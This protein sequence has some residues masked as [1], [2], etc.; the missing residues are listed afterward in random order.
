MA[1]VRERTSKRTNVTR[2]AV[3]YRKGKRQ[4]STTF[5]TQAG[6]DRFK[7]LV[8]L[9]GPEKAEATLDEGRQAGIT[10][11]DLF[12]KWIEWKA[13]TDVT[14]R[15]LRDYRRDYDNWIRARFGNREADGIDEL[16][17]QRWVDWM[18]GRGADPKSIGDRHMILGSLYRF[19]VA[20]SR[21]LVTQN[22]CLETQLPSKKKKAVK[23]FS[24]AQWD[25]MHAWAAQHEPDADDLLLFFASTG[26]R[27]S[28]VTPLTPEAVEDLGDRTFIDAQGDTHVIPV[29]N[30]AV[31]GVHRVDEHDRVVYVEGEGKSAAAMR[32]I[33]LPPA[34]ALMVRRRLLG[35][36]GPDGVRRPL[37]D[38]D[39]LFT[40]SRGGRWHAQNFINR[41][42]QRILDAVGIEKVKG[43]GPHYFRHT[44]V[45]MLERAGVSPAGM[46]RRIGHESID[47]TF[48]VYGGMIGN[49]LSPEELVRL[50]AQ[51]TRVQPAVVAGDVVRG[52]LV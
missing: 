27:F 3:L 37:G 39:M 15:T 13:T 25:R 7:Q 52:E 51:V 16:D 29:V 48:N 50:D 32:K 8:E 14:A 49:T 42:F 34:A 2:W 26:W 22:P 46:Q 30:V 28:E 45:A 18:G 21:R 38:R 43:M 19:G 40:N 24:L 6:A 10:V 4:T 35:L 36:P 5:P 23:G 17:V 9:L 12:E 41:E 20:R 1:T 31:L 33:N 47:T 11:D 44:H